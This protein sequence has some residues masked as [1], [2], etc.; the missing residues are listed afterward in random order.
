MLHDVTGVEVLDGYR[1]RLRFEDGAEGDLDVAQLL[2]FDGVFE[3][4]RDPAWFRQV[5]LDP[6][7]GTIC[8]PNGA[9]LAP[10]VLYEVVVGSRAA[11][12]S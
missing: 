10:E 3:P 9:D 2:T 12:H 8:W 7:L 5:R 6:E 1:L 4:L 11:A